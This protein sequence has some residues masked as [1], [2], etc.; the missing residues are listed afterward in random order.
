MLGAVRATGGKRTW[1]A[2]MPTTPSEV[3]ETPP[4]W[5][6]AS[7]WVTWAPLR[8]SL[9]GGGVH[10]RGDSPEILDGIYTRGGTADSH[11]LHMVERS[12]WCC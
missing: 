5:R 6:A 4:L 10:S 8:V 2:I 3:T 9:Q 7:Q 11:L 1:E 12:R